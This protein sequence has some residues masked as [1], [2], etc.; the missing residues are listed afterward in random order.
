MS[1]VT[2]TKL[3]AAIKKN[4]YE[5]CGSKSLY[6]VKMCEIE[7]CALWPYRLGDVGKLKANKD[8][9]LK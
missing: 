9:E 4:C 5:C 3:F 8:K 6:E 1:D 2:V 7:D